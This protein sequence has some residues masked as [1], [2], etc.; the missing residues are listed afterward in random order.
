MSRRKILDN[1]NPPPLN[2]NY[3]FL[4]NKF[5]KCCKRASKIRDNIKKDINKKV[6]MNKKN[7][8]KENETIEFNVYIYSNNHKLG[9]LKD[10]KNNNKKKFLKNMKKKE[11]KT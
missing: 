8:K 1:N 3:L 2:D 4:I 6:K 9:K 11:K 7:E 10:K 5:D